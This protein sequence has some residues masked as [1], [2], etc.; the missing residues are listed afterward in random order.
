ME[1][2]RYCDKKYAVLINM[3]NS[4]YKFPD[5]TF[6]CTLTNKD[7]CDICG[8]RSRQTVSKYID[9]L[10]SDGIIKYSEERSKYEIPEFTLTF[11]KDSAKVFDEFI[12]IS[13][14]YKRKKKLEV[15]LDESKL[16]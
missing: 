7:L 12:A 10:V 9:E 5:G 16:D 4:A 1:I 15:R 13:Q 2:L 6:Y 3:C 8:I 14:G 11:V